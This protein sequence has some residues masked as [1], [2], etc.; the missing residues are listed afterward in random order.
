MFYFICFVYLD[1]SPRT[2]ISK[3]CQILTKDSL[4]NSTHFES[5]PTRRSKGRR[6][7][8]AEDSPILSQEPVNVTWKWGNDNTPLRST[9]TT[10]SKICRPAKSSPSNNNLYRNSM[11]N[12]VPNKASTGALSSVV[13]EINSPKGFYKFQEEMRKIQFDNET[14][15]S[16]FPESPLKDTGCPLNISTPLM[17][18][19]V[20]EQTSD[21]DIGMKPYAIASASRKPVEII[22]LN[23]SLKDDLLNDS[24]FDQ[25][26]MTCT[27]NVEKKLSQVCAVANKRNVTE[28]ESTPPKKAMN[29]SNYM[30]LLQDESI[31]DILGN[32]DD[33][34]IMNG[35]N[36]N[37][38]KLM[39][40]KSMPQQQ[41]QQ[42]QPQQQ[43]K[44]TVQQQP[45]QI[46]CDNQ[47]ST[48]RKSFTRHESMPI[49]NANRTQIK[50]ISGK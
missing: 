37:N 19:S 44:Q 16:I 48:S 14:D 32:F 36:L 45:P 18:L 40:H 23:E 3:S 42:T 41:P 34:F 22:K 2:P 5:T 30:N 10:K 20:T 39:R 13:P 49:T 46:A 4:N 24:D 31:D 26:L 1:A 8:I 43:Q 7:I 28:E 35:I 29:T 47:P 12:N 15:N 38:S 25:I 17:N 6:G 9:S 27:D 50:S 33:T 11:K 21:D